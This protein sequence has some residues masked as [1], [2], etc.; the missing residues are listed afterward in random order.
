MR[1]TSGARGAG[2]SGS[3]AALAPA[4]RD[5]VSRADS[6][7]EE[8]A[9]PAWSLPSGRVGPV[10]TTWYAGGSAAQQAASEARTDVPD[11][12]GACVRAR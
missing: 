2:R 10:A 1:R 5:C 3:G 8:P 6:G 4:R 12:G 11:G 7:S 9:D